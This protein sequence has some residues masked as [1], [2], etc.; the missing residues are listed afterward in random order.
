MAHLLLVAP[1]GL[2]EHVYQAALRFS[3]VRVAL[4]IFWRADQ[5]PEGWERRRTCRS[6]LNT[7][8]FSPSSQVTAKQS[9]HH[10]SQP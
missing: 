5:V 3:G 7:C 10:D 2:A 4:C 9:Y 6:K 8:R 1:F